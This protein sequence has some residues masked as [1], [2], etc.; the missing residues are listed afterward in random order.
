MQHAIAA[1]FLVE[2]H[3]R[4]NGHRVIDEDFQQ[5][6]LG[7]AQREM[8]VVATQFA[9]GEVQLATSPYCARLLPKSLTFESERVGLGAK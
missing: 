9:S 5:R 2:L 6:E 4:E 1:Q 7:A 8:F 3:M